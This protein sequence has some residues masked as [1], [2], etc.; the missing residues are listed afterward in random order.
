MP[1]NRASYHSEGEVSLFFSSFGGNRGFILELRWG[2]IFKTRVCSATSGLLPSC[3]GQ[4]RILI[5]A[6][7]GNRNDSLGES[8]DTGSPS[9]YHSFI[10][11]P[12][13]YKE[14]S[15]IASS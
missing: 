8:G 1:L 5:E 11:I 10:G 4:L 2:W 6:W 7:Q 13:H 12:I 9:I 14:D 15:G 3:E